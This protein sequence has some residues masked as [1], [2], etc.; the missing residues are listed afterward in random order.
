MNFKEYYKTR[1]LR[2]QDD[3]VIPQDSPDLPEKDDIGSNSDKLSKFLSCILS[4]YDNVQKVIAKMQELGF[5][6]KSGKA[7]EV[8]ASID[9]E[10]LHREAKNF[11]RDTKNVK[12]KDMGDMIKPS[13]ADAGTPATDDATGG[14]S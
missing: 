9:W 4:N 14:Y 11:I 10:G 13:A 12:K 7:Q 3:N 1:K 6:D 8:L 2:E 5:E